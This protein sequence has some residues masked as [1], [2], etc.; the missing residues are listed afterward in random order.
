MLEWLAIILLAVFGVM[1]W[2]HQR[3]LSTRR[4]YAEDSQ[5]ALHPARAFHLITFFR[6]RSGERV[7]DSARQFLDALGDS[8]QPQLIYAGQA[9][10]TVASTQVG[11]VAWD[12]VILLQF[13]SRTR[14]YRE[15]APRIDAARDVFADSYLH[16]MQRDRGAGLMIPQKLLKLQLLE[17]LRGRWRPPSLEPHPAFD[18][19]PEFDV[20]RQRIARLHALHVLNDRGL[21]VINLIKHNN[22]A[23]PVR[24]V[25]LSRAMLLLMAAHRH[26]PLHFGRSIAL[27]GNARFDDILAIYY[28][29]PDY[30][31]QLLYSQLFHSTLK[32]MQ[33]AD[34]MVVS[35]APLTGML[36]QS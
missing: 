18:A 34:L 21:V 17:V 15:A 20:W 24:D 14:Y 16:G 33:A 1:A 26:G 29:S 28:P 7:I 3:Y 32:D 9:G 36:R 13:P 12:G 2:Q 11:E 8:G 31:A 4:E 10:F 19:A 5:Q 22:P 27:E 25:A 35:T 30:Y 23:Q 6:V